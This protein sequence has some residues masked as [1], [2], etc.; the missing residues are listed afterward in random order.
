CGEVLAAET[1]EPL[2]VRRRQGLTLACRSEAPPDVEQPAGTVAACRQRSSECQLDLSLVPHDRLDPH[3]DRVTEPVAAAGTPSDDRGPGRVQLEELARQAA[4]G[5]EPF[6]YLAEA[7]EEARGDQSRDL[8]LERLLPAAR[9]QR[10]VEQPCE[11]EL[12]RRVLDL[13]RR[14]LARRGVLGE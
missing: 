7:G 6:E 3:L 1:G 2:G 10:V 8:A 4:R 14:P 12:V 5:Q 9:E 11:A 13:R